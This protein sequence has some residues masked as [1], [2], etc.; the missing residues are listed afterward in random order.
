MVGIFLIIF[1]KDTISNR[2][3]EA[4]IESVATGIG[5]TLGNK[6]AVI[7]RFNIDST[8]LVITN[9]HL[10]AGHKKVKNRENDLASI[11]KK[12]F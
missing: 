6:G 8:S 9:C 11:H 2:I 10:T 7:C 5:G 12:A 4:F 1:V 3:S